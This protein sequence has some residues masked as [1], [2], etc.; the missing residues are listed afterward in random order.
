MRN[1]TLTILNF[2]NGEV[3]QYNLNDKSKYFCINTDDF[4]IE[5][6]FKDYYLNIKNIEY[7]ISSKDGIINLLETN[8]EPM[9]F[10]L[11]K[12]NNY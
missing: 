8:K 6:F 7:M 4:L 2:E 1:Y 3:L 5:N 10:N 9:P 11:A 12:I